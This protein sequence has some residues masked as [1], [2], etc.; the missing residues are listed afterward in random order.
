MTPADDDAFAP[1]YF[2]TRSDATSIG[3]PMVDALRFETCIGVANHASG[4][5]YSVAL[6]VA[7]EIVT[8]PTTHLADIGADLLQRV[9]DQIRAKSALVTQ[10][11]AHETGTRTLLGGRDRPAAA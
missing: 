5:D 1:E 3:R 9:V 6:R 11:N 7:D 4:R 2:E 8:F 10:L